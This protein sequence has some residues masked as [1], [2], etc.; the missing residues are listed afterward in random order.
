MNSA[1][2]KLKDSFQRD[3]CEKLGLTGTVEVLEEDE[4]GEDSSVDFEC[5]IFGPK[6]HCFGYAHIRFRGE[7]PE[8]NFRVCEG[9]GLFG[10]QDG[11]QQCF[12][13]YPTDTRQLLRDQLMDY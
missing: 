12:E 5:R 8:G 10:E 11:A 9:D 1:F 7:W 3:V 2:D 4:D 6:G 13:D